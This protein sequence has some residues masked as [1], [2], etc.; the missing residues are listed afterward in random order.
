MQKTDR[1]GLPPTP[2][3]PEIAKAAVNEVLNAIRGYFN[4][5]YKKLRVLDVGSGRGEYVNE[6]AKYFNEVVG[7]EPQK[8]AYEYAKRKFKKNNVRFYNS[9]IEDF[10]STEKFDIVVSLTVF[11]HMSDHKKSYDKIF[12]LLKS[13]GVIYMTAPNKYWLFEQHYGLPFLS[14]L[15]LNLANIYLKIFKGIPSYKDC[16]YSMGYVATQKFFDKYQCTYKFILPYDI[17]GAYF[18][19][20]NTTSIS[21]KIRDLGIQLIKISPFFW[22]FSKGFIMVI[23]KK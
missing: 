22:N 10:K 14:W 13:K 1:Y 12:A 5:D 3:A 17:S 20:N 7:V 15:P 4:T 8:E 23:R 21:S 11:E 16:S 9:A 6:L 19:C 2:I 18:G